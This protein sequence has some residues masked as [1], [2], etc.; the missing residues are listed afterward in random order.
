MLY[1]PKWNLDDASL[2]LLEAA[3][4]LRNDGWA[5]G[6]L[7]TQDGRSCV[8]GVLRGFRVTTLTVVVAS[9]RLVKHLGL[10]RTD[11]LMIWN[12]APE[13]TK[14]EVIAALEAAA[15]HREG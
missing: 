1:D 8:V 12:D 6:H 4:K 13:R 5:Q 14:E 11:D 10:S 2:A 9:D 7:R 15:Y 3:D